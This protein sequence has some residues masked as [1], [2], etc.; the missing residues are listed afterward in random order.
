M[1]RLSTFLLGAMLVVSLPAHTHDAEDCL[2]L[3]EQAAQAHQQMRDVFSAYQELR[4]S[5]GAEHH[6]SKVL[7]AADH[8]LET[9][10]DTLNKWVEVLVCSDIIEYGGE[11][12]QVY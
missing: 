6:S 3:V 1:A 4:V 5:S 10:T 12:G 7:K 2:V 11:K 8:T 9:V